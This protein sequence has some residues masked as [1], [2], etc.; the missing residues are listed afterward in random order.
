MAAAYRQRAEE[1]RRIAENA[2]FGRKDRD[3][4]FD[5]ARSY[6]ALA[7]EIDGADTAKRVW[8]TDLAG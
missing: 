3:A 6:E 5:L 4:F 2:L 1:C 7:E 8:Q